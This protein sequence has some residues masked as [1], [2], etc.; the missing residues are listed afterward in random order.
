MH[1]HGVWGKDWVKIRSYWDWEGCLAPKLSSLFSIVLGSVQIQSVNMSPLIHLW[2]FIPSAIT[3]L[4]AFKSSLLFLLCSVPVE[5]DF[6]FCIS[7]GQKNNFLCQSFSV[8]FKGQD[9]C[10]RSSYTNPLL[11]LSRSASTGFSV[12]HCSCNLLSSML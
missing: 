11:H 8:C 5:V 10:H 3:T 9:F 1:A 12:W 2:S 7:D 4:R 6:L